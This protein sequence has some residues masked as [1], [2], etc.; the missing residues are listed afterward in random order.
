MKS[1]TI[2]SI[3]FISSKEELYL[4]T[5][6]LDY[7]NIWRNQKKKNIFSFNSLIWYNN[8]SQFSSY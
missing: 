3:F 5:L 1:D 2:Y 7:S 6:N 4:I 8:L